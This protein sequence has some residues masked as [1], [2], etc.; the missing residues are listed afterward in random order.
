[1]V[2]FAAVLAQFDAVLL[3]EVYAAGETKLPGSDGA[4]LAARVPGARFIAALADLPAAILGTAR[5]GDIVL[6]LGAGSIASVPSAV[7]QLAYAPTRREGA[8]A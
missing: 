1:M 6:T 5:E 8:Q 7:Q 3:A 4:I 2:D